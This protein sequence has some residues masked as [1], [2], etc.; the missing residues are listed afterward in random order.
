[1]A[2]TDAWVALM[3]NHWS[4]DTEY[5]PLRRPDLFDLL[6]CELTARRRYADVERLLRART[7]R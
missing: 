4:D 1:M 6:A 2:R 5:S 3:L 7:D